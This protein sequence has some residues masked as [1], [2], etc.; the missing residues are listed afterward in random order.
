[1]RQSSGY[2]TQNQKARTANGTYK[3]LKVQWLNEA[4]CPARAG[5]SDGRQFCAPKSTLRQAPKRYR[6]FYA[7]MQLS[8]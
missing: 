1:M 4:L 8:R 6:Q 5:F 3:K 2:L 7:T